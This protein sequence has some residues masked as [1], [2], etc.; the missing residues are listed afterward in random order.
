[1]TF[2]TAIFGFAALRVDR[3]QNAPVLTAAIR[4]ASPGTPRLAGYRFFRESLVFYAGKPVPRYEHR[5]AERLEAFLHETEYP[6]L[7]T[8]DEHEE[9]LRRLFPGE[10]SVLIRRPRFL[11]SGQ[12]VVLTRRL[13]R[14]V[15]QLA[16]EPPT[17]SRQ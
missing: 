15:P 6:Y 13:D 10:L 17:T 14:G 3:H 7:V 5:D 1:V 9:E 12:V 2:L 4:S 8:T 16:A 11:R